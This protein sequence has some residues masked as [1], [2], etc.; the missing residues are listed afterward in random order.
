MYKQEQGKECAHKAKRTDLRLSQMET[1]EGETSSLKTQGLMVTF[2]YKRQPSEKAKG[3]P[4]V[5]TLSLGLKRIRS[6]LC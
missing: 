1:K 3:F 6:S 5:T 2:K 4:R